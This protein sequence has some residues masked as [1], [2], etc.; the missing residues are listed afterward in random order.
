M[1]QAKFVKTL[2][3]LNDDSIPAHVVWKNVYRGRSVDDVRLG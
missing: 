1:L 2:D 3:N